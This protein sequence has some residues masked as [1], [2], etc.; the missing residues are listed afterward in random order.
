MQVVEK[1]LY[2]IVTQK[3]TRVIH[4]ILMLLSQIM[5]KKIL[6]FAIIEDG[7]LYRMQESSSYHGFLCGS[8]AC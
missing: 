7:F 6:M 5:L 3:Q 4:T 1:V 8:E 2:S